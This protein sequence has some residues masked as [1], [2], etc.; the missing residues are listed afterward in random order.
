MKKGDNL[1]S[2]AE[3]YDMTITEIAQLNNLKK[4]YPIRVGQKLKIYKK[5]YRRFRL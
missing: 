2:I 5:F 1:S 4:P 3:K